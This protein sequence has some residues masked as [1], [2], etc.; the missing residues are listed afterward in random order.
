M[1]Q[2]IRD[3]SAWLST[4]IGQHH[5]PG[6]TDDFTA[7]QTFDAHYVDNESQTVEDC[8]EANAWL[9]SDWVPLTAGEVA[10]DLRRMSYTRADLWATAA[11]LTDDSLGR[12]L[13]GQRWPI[14][15]ILSHVA[16]GEVHYLDL[17]GLSPIASSASRSDRVLQDLTLMR[18]AVVENLPTLIDRHLVVG[19]RGDQSSPR[20]ML[21][22]ILY[23]ERDHTLHAQQLLDQMMACL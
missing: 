20:K 7:V 1:P 8:Y 10:S 23:H 9:Q 14:R 2:A 4:Q 3:H 13:P 22:R 19:R 16:Q 17:L 6:D 5:D 11:G 21:R 12:S 15:G 18:S